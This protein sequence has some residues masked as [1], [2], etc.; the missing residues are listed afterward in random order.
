MVGF[1]EGMVTGLSDD[2]EALK[3]GVETSLNSE[4][5]EEMHEP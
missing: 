4:M 2:A 1:L 3:N 5:Q